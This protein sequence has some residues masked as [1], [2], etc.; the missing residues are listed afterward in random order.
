MLQVRPVTDED[1]IYVLSNPWDAT[2]R[3]LDAN[4]VHKLSKQEI[5][6]RYGKDYSTYIGLAIFDADKP[7]K[8]LAILGA[9]PEEGEPNV[10]WTWF[11]APKDFPMF[12]REVTDF[13]RAII[14]M[15]AMLRGATEVRAYSPAG[16]LPE[17]KA[18]FRRLGFH[19]AQDF[20]IPMNSG[21]NIYMFQRFFR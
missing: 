3:D 7:D 4:E 1:I 8:V 11:F 5:L 15:E 19:K 2:Q 18:W 17:G 16:E 21:Y 10:W 9:Y 13:T 14:E 12:W 6:Q 20:V